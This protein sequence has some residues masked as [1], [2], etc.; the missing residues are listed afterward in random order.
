M[1][2]LRHAR[3]RSPRGTDAALLANERACRSFNVALAHEAFA[4]EKSRDANRCQV[5]EIGGGA[6]PALA[7]GDTAGRNPRRQTP[8]DGERCDARLGA[9][10][11]DASERRASSKR[12]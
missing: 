2:E 12:S 10:I 8:A 9:S 11:V 5:F 3:H 4:D 7:D 6:D 1:S